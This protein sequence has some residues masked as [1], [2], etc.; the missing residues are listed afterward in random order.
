MYKIGCAWRPGELEDSDYWTLDIDYVQEERDAL[1]E[2]GAIIQIHGE[3]LSTCMV[4]AKFICLT[5][6][7]DGFH[8]VEI[9]TQL[10]EMAKVITVERMEFKKGKDD[11]ESDS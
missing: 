5:L 6:N 9:F 2:H 11:A 10:M 4:R 8:G 7:D 3:S 1:K